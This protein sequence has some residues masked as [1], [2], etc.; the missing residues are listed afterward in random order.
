M[1]VYTIGFTQKTAE[2][3]FTLLR[4]NRVELL[5][6]VRLNNKSQLAGFTKDCDLSFFLRELCS[7][8]YLHCA[9]FAPSKEL[10]SSYQKKAITWDDYE[11]M[12]DEILEKRRDYQQFL[13]R[14]SNYNR[15]CLL[16]SEPTAYR[17]HRRLL[18][19]KIKSTFP[20]EVEVVHL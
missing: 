6:D 11:R 13:S 1:T 2:Q 16:C 19:E 12:Y 14:F 18:A 20:E 3:F 9:E 4:E 7:A 5:I 8:K 15:V 17:C 10:L